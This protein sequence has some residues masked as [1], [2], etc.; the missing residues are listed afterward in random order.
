MSYDAHSLALTWILSDK[1]QQEFVHRLE[2]TRQ[3]LFVKIFPVL[4]WEGSASSDRPGISNTICTQRGTLVTGATIWWQQINAV[5]SRWW[6]SPILC[7]PSLFLFERGAAQ[8]DLNAG[9]ALGG[10]SMNLFL[11]L[12]LFTQGIFPS[13]LL[14]PG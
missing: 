5:C 13:L 9:S 8:A 3:L 4:G 2:Q 12:V 10:V 14:P 1:E 7:L 11:L 6:K